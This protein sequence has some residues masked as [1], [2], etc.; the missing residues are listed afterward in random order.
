[1]Y[2]SRANIE[3]LV[4]KR[5][6]SGVRLLQRAL[7]YK[8]TTIRLKKYLDITKDWVLQLVNTRSKINNIYL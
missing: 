2:H 4:F 6:N 3:P 1:M 5:E 8:T 7:T